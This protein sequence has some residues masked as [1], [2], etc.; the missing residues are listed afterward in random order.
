MKTKTL[1]HKVKFKVGPED[2]YMALMDSRRHAA[3]TRSA[4]DIS[5]KVGGK[6][7]AYDGY[8]TGKNLELVPNKKIV[9]TWRASGWPADHDS[10]VTF[11]LKKMKNGSEL[12]LVHEGV[13]EPESKSIDQGWIDYYW[14][15]MKEL[16]E[17]RN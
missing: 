2:I 5:P 10:K 1:R 9:Q 8:I 16:L 6:I 15:P 7:K 3:F 13:P 14:K 4:A 17:G 11:R 12:T